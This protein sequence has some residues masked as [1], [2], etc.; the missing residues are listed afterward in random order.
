MDLDKFNSIVEINERS[1][2]ITARHNHFEYIG[3]ILSNNSHNITRAMEEITGYIGCRD[4]D[5]K[6][7]FLDYF[8]DMIQQESKDFSA[9]MDLIKK[10]IDEA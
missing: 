7:I 9:T 1:R 2:A 10:E 4:T 6:N 8:K 5:F 3:R